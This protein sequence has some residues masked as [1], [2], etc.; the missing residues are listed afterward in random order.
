MEKWTLQEAKHKCPEFSLTGGCCF[1][2]I[3]LGWEV[4]AQN[5]HTNPH[6]V[7]QP[8]RSFPLISALCFYH[9]S[10]P[11]PKALG[12]CWPLHT[13]PSA[14]GCSGT[15]EHGER[16]C[17]DVH[18]AKNNNSCK[19]L[20]QA[21]STAV[22][23]ITSQTKSTNTLENGKPLFKE[24]ALVAAWISPSPSN[25]A[26]PTPK[27]NQPLTEPVSQKWKPK[28]W[29]EAKPL[30]QWIIWSLCGDS[31]KGQHS[32]F[33]SGRGAEASSDHL[34][35][36]MKPPRTSTMAKTTQQGKN[37][38]IKAAQK[39]LINPSNSAHICIFF[40][41]LVQQFTAFKSGIFLCFINQALSCHI[42]R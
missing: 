39:L 7:A 2:K 25:N 3:A 18:V 38:A 14:K 41:K 22:H 4:S 20:L 15:V 12:F 37:P 36:L 26:A 9:C 8:W 35:L 10:L 34:T 29:E 11:S 31:W 42:W 21:N 24:F 5:K 6:A 16:V 33:A 1:Y 27:P 40:F 30:L 13:N 32:L 28:L 17:T 23:L 19:S